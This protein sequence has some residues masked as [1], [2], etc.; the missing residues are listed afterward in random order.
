MAEVTLWCGVHGEGSVISVKV[1]RDATVEA[2]QGAIAGV[3]GTKQR[4]VPPSLLTLHLARK[5]GVW[6]KDDDNVEGF[7]RR[8]VGTEHQEMQ[9]AR[10][11]N[12]PAC[13]GPDFEL[14]D[15]E[16]HVLVARRLFAGRTDL[17]VLSDLVK[18]YPLEL[19]SLPE[20]KM[21]VEVKR[22][23][24]PVSDFRVLSK[25]ITLDLL[26]EG[27]VMALLMDLAG[28]WHFF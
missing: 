23:I 3:L 4:V 2:L 14:G 5:Y 22:A 9:P 21:L 27:L 19:I 24:E 10:K 28:N 25:L 13:F 26:S 8:G 1:G 16:I 20:V 7:L 18:K 15:K 17:L 11:L 12:D 6:L